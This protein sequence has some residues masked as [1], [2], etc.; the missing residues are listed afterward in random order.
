MT[1]SADNHDDLFAEIHRLVTASLEG[2]ISADDAARLDQLLRESSE[3]RHLYILYLEGALSLNLWADAAKASQPASNMAA[4][5]QLTAAESDSLQARR[6]EV[7][8]PAPVPFLR[9]SVAVVLNPITLAAFGVVVALGVSAL[10]FW[11]KSA[12][13]PGVGGSTAHS[14]SP[15]VVARSTLADWEPGFAPAGAALS[16]GQ[17]LKLRSGFV[18][19][20]FD[21]Q[22]NAVIQGPADFQIA[23]RNSCRLDVGQLTA[24]APASAHGFKI[25]TPAGTLTD[26]GT[27][28]G[29]V[30]KGKGKREKG[31]VE[32]SLEAVTE[33]HVFRGEVEVAAAF[34]SSKPRTIASGAGI[35]INPENKSVEPLTADPQRFVRAMPVAIPIVNH[36]FEMG[37]PIGN[38]K[39]GAVP[40]G[41]ESKGIAQVFDPCEAT[42]ASDDGNAYY[43]GSDEPPGTGVLGKMS[44]P[45]VGFMYWGRVAPSLSQTLAATVQPN[46]KYVLTIAIGVRNLG[47]ALNTRDF[48]GYY[49]ELLA[50]G[51]RLGAGVQG[52]FDALNAM[53][54]G[55]AH[56]TF[57]DVNYTFTTGADVPAG[58]PLGIRISMAKN[59]RNKYLDIDNVRLL[60][61]PLETDGVS[62]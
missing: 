8:K 12:G 6:R 24:R 59:T 52:D 62:P 50:G 38:G 55:Q 22:A 48:G 19:I 23:D 17:P 18:E 51:E 20:R 31:K 10:L 2:E 57:T 43:R 60:A 40:S 14:A 42:T 58:R 54:G 45:Q 41:W 21:S 35:V 16:A 15:A 56:G 9:S 33:V 46:T 13:V 25:I 28:F 32:E 27:E 36:D 37:T 11:P 4:E 30:V 34:E 7:A 26:L 44:G 1:H 53:A 61:I 29:V 47:K 5:T 3:A 39:L 49:I